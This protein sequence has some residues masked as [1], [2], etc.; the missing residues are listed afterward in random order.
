MGRSDLANAVAL[1]SLVFNGARIVGPAVAGLLIARFG[2]ALAFLLNGLSFVA[3]LAALLAT[4]TPGDPDPAGRLGIR[5]GV[6]GA[7]GYAA[8]TPPVAF[9][10]AA[11]RR[12]QHPRAQLQRGGA[13]HRARTC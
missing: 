11:D 7:L 3:V 1:N 12:G 6:W 10:L 5:A 4:R 9:T 13:A 8:R 2:V